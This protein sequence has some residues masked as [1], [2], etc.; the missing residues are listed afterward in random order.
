MEAGATE[1]GK[2]EKYW[3][4]RAEQLSRVPPRTRWWDD[5][6]T[7]RHI[8]A[9]VV[10]EAVDGVHVGFH[11]RI[12]SAFGGRA[13]D[14]AVSVGCGTGTKEMDLI[15][16]GVVRHFDLYEISQSS[17][18]A[19]LAAAE[20]QG[21][22]DRL[23]FHHADAFQASVDGRY[24]LVYWNNALHHMPDVFD[25]LRWSYRAL[26]AGGLLAL[27]DYVGP[28]RFQWTDT[29]LKWANR[30]RSGLPERLLRSPYEPGKA[31]SMEVVR[32]TPESVIEVDPSEAMDSERTLGALREVFGE[33]EYMPTGGA[34]YHL[35]LNDIFWNFTSAEDMDHLRQI[36]LMDQLLAETGTTQYAVAFAWKR[37][38]EPSVDTS[39]NATPFVERVKSFL[40]R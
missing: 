19:G 10:G 6:T 7:R 23:T 3:D 2:A 32:P 29:N 36:L 22:S 1:F 25:A 40:R 15:H 28:S 17:I 34:L 13:V 11:M 18:D 31:V 5:E 37:A 27:D 39:P 33:F 12:A 20:Q 21:I 4:E 8:N 35:A 9:V 30:V 14:R 16:R 38:A 26:S 24:E